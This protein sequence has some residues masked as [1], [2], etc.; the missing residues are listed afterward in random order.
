MNSSQR[1]TTIMQAMV[2]DGHDALPTTQQ[3]PEPTVPASRHG[4]KYYLP[5][6]YKPEHEE[7]RRAAQTFNEAAVAC[8][9]WAAGGSQ[10]HTKLHGAMEDAA[11]L[12]PNLQQHK[13]G[14]VGELIKQIKK[15]AQFETAN[16]RDV[17]KRHRGEMEE[18]RKCTTKN[19]V[20]KAQHEI[21]REIFT[22]DTHGD[23]EVKQSH[24][25]IWHPVHKVV[26]HPEVVREGWEHFGRCSMSK[27]VPK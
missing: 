16:Q 18:R 3:T 15:C 2:R 14:S 7:H 10:D 11:A 4:L 5:K 8:K 13:R 19:G 20:T 25:A 1:F 26:S 12:A 6:K 9:R 24:G 17:I 22:S 23:S 27:K 21:N